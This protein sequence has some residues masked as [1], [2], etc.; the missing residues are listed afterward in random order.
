MQSARLL[1]HVKKFPDTDVSVKVE[2]RLQTNWTVCFRAGKTQHAP[3]PMSAARD[4]CAAL[5]SSTIGVSQQVCAHPHVW[6]NRYGISSL[7]ACVL[8]YNAVLEQ[9]C[10]MQKPSGEI[11]WKAMVAA[12]AS[13]PS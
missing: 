6:K 12:R 5:H 7:A 9:A 13:T 1:G 4:R 3:T 11:D 2:I 8:L 10:A